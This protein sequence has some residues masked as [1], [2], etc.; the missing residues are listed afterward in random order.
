MKVAT[1]FED[2]S[3]G[4]SDVPDPESVNNMAVVKVY[5]APMCTEYKALL[6]KRAGKNFG[7]EAVGEVVAIERPGRIQIGD[8]VIVQP[9]AP[10]GSCYICLCGDYIY[11]E[12]GLRGFP[13]GFKPNTSTMAQFLNKVDW[14]LTPIP[15]EMSYEHASM[16]CCGLGP[17]YGAVRKMNV[18]SYDTVLITGLGPVG[19]GGVI[20]STYLGAN[21]IGVDPNPYRAK[22]ALGLGA[23]AVFDPDDDDILDKIKQE[24]DGHLG[25]DKAMDCSGSASAHRLIIDAVRRRGEV[26]FIGE[27]KSFPLFASDDML[28]KG[29]SLHGIW[30]YNISDSL[31][32]IKV[33][34]QNSDKL[35][36]FITHKF[37]MSQVQHAWELQGTMA[38]GK[39][40]LDPWS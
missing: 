18:N 11:C 15:D 35:D 23:A 20:N 21:V 29:I 28:R 5:V 31:N 10:C 39:V 25:V 4:L 3:A 19:L 13:T 33:I 8:R 36:K 24:T 32:L 30:H 27:G 9:G 22:L 2:G 1:I 26:S 34:E 38:C 17:T 40:L 6:G 16:A 14:L 37:P 12:N 7:H